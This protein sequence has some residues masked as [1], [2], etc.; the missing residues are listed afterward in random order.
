MASRARSSCQER[1]TRLWP[2]RQG[3]ELLAP[4][5]GWFTEGCGTRDLK[6]AKALL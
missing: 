5:H 2:D 1:P 4:H 6:E 3:R